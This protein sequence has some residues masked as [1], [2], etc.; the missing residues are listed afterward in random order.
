MSGSTM[1]P[2][3]VRIR[4]VRGSI[5]SPGPGTV[6]YGGNTSCVELRCADAVL[7]LDA[8]SGIR[9]LGD[10]LLR[11]FGSRMMSAS[12]L[13]SHTHWDHIQ[14]FPFFAP[15]YQ[16]EQH[17]S[18]LAAAGQGARLEQ[19]LR[20]QMHASHF[21]IELEQMHGL[22]RIEELAEDRTCVGPFA[23]R[24][25]G[26][27]HP[28]GCAAFRIEANG[29]SVVYAPD[30]EPYQSVTA[31]EAFTEFVRD[32]D[33]LILD[34][35]YTAEEYGLRVGW[36]HGCL[37]DSVQLA[38]DANVRRLLLFHHD[39]AHDDE[40]IDLMVIAARALAAGSKLQIDAAAENQPLLLNCTNDARQRA[41]AIPMPRLHKRGAGASRA[42]DF[43][44]QLTASGTG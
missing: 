20:N 40:Q 11:E 1:L 10:D 9:D 15:L 12:L 18:V 33:L 43:A 13:V 30:H 26:T 7:I 14:G 28:G 8:G 31:Q 36:G 2:L 23:I 35:Q 39:P 22:S 34:T 21:P 5:P 27:N 44:S 6:R 24:T 3:T 32:S 42:R 17:L 41:S 25:T 16:P 38:M 29:V 19:A 37:P 4:G